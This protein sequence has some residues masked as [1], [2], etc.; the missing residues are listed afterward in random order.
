VSL[1]TKQAAYAPDGNNAHQIGSI[2][3]FE[4]LGSRSP[5]DIRP[6]TWEIDDPIGSTWGYTKDMKI[7]SAGTIIAKLV[8]T[9]SKNGNYTLNLSPMAD[10][11][12]PE[13][14]QKTLL[15][16]GAWL[17]V[18]GEAIYGTHSWVKFGEGAK[19]G[20]NYRFT[21][22]GDSLYAIALGWPQGGQATITSLASGDGAPG[23]VEKVELLG[24]SGSLDFTQDASGLHITLPAQPT[25][26]YAYAFKISGLKL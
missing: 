23:K 19:G 14:Q 20:Q 1:I 15:G 16:I 17:D 18:N 2:I 12:I 11:T 26:G 21:V 24:G 13:A 22:K 3:D 4:K 8:D 5:T 10:G 7:F 25:E 9:A 6:G